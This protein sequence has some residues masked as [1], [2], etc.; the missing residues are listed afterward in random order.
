MVIKLSAADA[1]NKAKSAKRVIENNLLREQ[2]LR[3]K[4]LQEKKFIDDG[5]D[6]Q[7]Y[8]LYEA[9]INKKLQVELDL[10]FYYKRLVE[11]GIKV[12]EIGLVRNKSANFQNSADEEALIREEILNL[13]DEFVKKLKSDPINSYSDLKYIRESNLRALQLVLDSEDRWERF[14]GDDKFFA[15]VSSITKDKLFFILEDINKKIREL[16]KLSRES[17]NV[18]L[19][20]A[21]ESNLIEGEYDWTSSDP[22]LDVI[23]P[24]TEGNKF[25]VSW[26]SEVGGIFTNQVLL[27]YLGLT[28]LCTHRGQSFLQVL[29]GKISENA[30]AGSSSIFLNFRLEKDG[31]HFINGVNSIFCCRPNDIVE[32]LKYLK[33]T[34]DN[35]DISDESY[36]L[37]VSW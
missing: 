12:I 11:N 10:V 7:K 35:L 16:K 19:D 21:F 36:S 31:W 23:S 28:W 22:D 6:C 15:E 24:T 33:Y 3:K 25:I 13:F 26:D 14:I 5:F 2:E 4:L 32:L 17:V 9:A 34:I 8:A 30:D 37:R 29:F 27:S 20:D 18:D 1:R